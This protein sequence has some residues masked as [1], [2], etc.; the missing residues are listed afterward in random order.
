MKNHS[1]SRVSCRTNLRP[2]RALCFATIAVAIV[3]FAVA[4][5]YYVD[6][7]N[8]LDS[9]SGTTTATPWKTYAKLNKPNGVK[10]GPGD[11]I[12]FKRGGT[13]TGRLNPVCQGSGTARVVFKDYGIATD[14]APLLQ[15][16]SANEPAV[17]LESPSYCTFE[18]FKITHTGTTEAPRSG[19]YIQFYSSTTTPP[20]QTTVLRDVII[21]NNEITD[22]W[23]LTGRENGNNYSQAAIFVRFNGTS[24]NQR[25]KVDG[26]LIEGNY[27]HDTHCLSIQSVGSSNYAGSVTDPVADATAKE[28][29]AD[30]FIIRNNTMNKTGGDHILVQCADA[31]LIEN[32]AGYDAG[33]NAKQDNNLTQ[34]GMWVCYHTRNSLF[35]YNEVARTVN[36]GIN[37]GDSQAFDVDYGT[38]DSHIFQYNYTHENAGGVLIVMP[39]KV[40]SPDTQPNLPKTVVYRYNVSVNDG[41]NT[42]SRS[43]F[44]IDPRV[45]VSTAHIHNN[46]FFN[47]RPEGI[48]IKDVESSYFTNN[49]FYASSGTYP[50]RPVFSNNAYFGHTPDVDDP[51]QITAN[52]QMAGPFP[53]GDAPNALFN[54][55]TFQIVPAA[56]RIS[57]LRNIADPYKLLGSSP[58]INRGRPLTTPVVLATNDYWGNSLNQGRIDIGAHEAGGGSNPDPTAAYYTDTTDASV[59]FAPSGTASQPGVFSHIPDSAAYD[60]TRLNSNTPGNMMEFTFSGTSVE[61]YGKTGPN[62]GKLAFSHN[63]GP[64]VATVNCYSGTAKDQVKLYEANAFPAGP[65]NTLRATVVAGQSPSTGSYVG[66]DYFV[67]RGG[68]GTVQPLDHVSI[69][70]D[71]ESAGVTLLPNSAAWISGRSQDYYYGTDYRHDNNTAASVPK[72]VQFTPTLPFAATF[73]VYI[74]HTMNSVN[75]SNAMVTVNHAAGAQQFIMNQRINGGDWLLLG[76]F[77]FAAGTAGNVTVSNT[78]ANGNVIADGVK[79]VAPSPQL[80]P[81]TVDNPIVSNL[82]AYSLTYSATSNWTHSPNATLP[83]DPTFYNG[84]KSVANIVGSYVEFK[85]TGTRASLFVKK[86]SNLGKLK[87]YVN[88]TLTQTVDC[89]SPSVINQFKIYETATLP[90]QLNTLRAVVETRNTSS[91]GN[92]VGID[93]FEYQP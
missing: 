40:A 62:F 27:I 51:Y 65:G 45:G 14:P 23:G 1:V 82:P 83:A 68:P 34:A 86:A 39:R 55:Q 6:S 28:L 43:Q 37:R 71:T 35:Q 26:L 56:N 9:Y 42:G 22:V 73:K 87:I 92:F 88:G 5:D 69:E 79:F 41:R 74:R 89:Y 58:L 32:N 81:V 46:V 12:H 19:I 77:P 16:Q 47:N 53:T 48:N 24:A 25:V 30:N 54:P 75:A 31:P 72:S 29:W 52:P 33:V 36:Q 15:G 10:F 4:V 44:G 2:L 93:K 57:A 49:I 11:T 21:R 66:L 38:W 20:G 90:S 78:G 91:T 80:P 7:A 60:G 64:V 85:F 17:L 3:P 61:V 67:T 63:G 70:L 18:S 84:T 13:W 59:I 50:R 76:S 8:G